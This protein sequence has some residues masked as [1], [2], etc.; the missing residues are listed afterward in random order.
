MMRT[1]KNQK[2]TTETLSQPVSFLKCN[3]AHEPN[4]RDPHFQ[5][6]PVDQATKDLYSGLTNKATNE[7]K[8]YSFNFFHWMVQERM[9]S[10]PYRKPR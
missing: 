2:K 8:D 3:L 7:W 6:K 9:L 5:I 1:V 10:L 4:F